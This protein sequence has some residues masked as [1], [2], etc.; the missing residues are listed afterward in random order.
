MNLKCIKNEVKCVQ[1]SASVGESENRHKS[2]TGSFIFISKSDST[3][4]STEKK[5]IC[6]GNPSDGHQTNDVYLLRT[7]SEKIREEG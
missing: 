2:N 3:T 4:D 7:C 5:N 1:S 6:G